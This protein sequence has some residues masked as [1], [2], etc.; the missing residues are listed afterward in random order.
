MRTTLDIPDDLMK[1]VQKELGFKSKI[2]VVIYS[3]KEVL[4]RKRVKGLKE[5]VGKVHLELDLDQTRRRVKRPK[6]L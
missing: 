2:D 6:A 3:L 1:E 4:R 5:L